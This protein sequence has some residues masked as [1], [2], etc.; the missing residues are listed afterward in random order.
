MVACSAS[1][2]RWGLV[3]VPEGGLLGQQLNRTSLCLHDC[4]IQGCDLFVGFGRSGDTDIQ[5]TTITGDIDTIEV[6]RK[7][8]LE[9]PNPSRPLEDR[10]R[11]QVLAMHTEM[12]L[13]CLAQAYRM[14]SHAS[15]RHPQGSGSAE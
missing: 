4:S 7:K 1:A 14:R 15:R 3:F 10:E 5:N 8:R 12:V 13:E 9:G 6:L 11:Q 2:I